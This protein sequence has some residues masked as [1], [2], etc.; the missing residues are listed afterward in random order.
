MPIQW[1]SSFCGGG[2]G[3]AA[4]AEGVEDDVAG[5][6][7]GLDDALEQ[8]EGFLGGIA[9]ASWRPEQSMACEYQPRIL[10]GF[11]LVSIQISLEIMD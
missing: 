7:G 10:N 1:R 11:A 4:A 2:D 6:A 5:V 9:E 8:G 3:G